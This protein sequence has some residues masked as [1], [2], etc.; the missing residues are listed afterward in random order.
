[1]AS[2]E[3]TAF[4]FLSVS[5]EITGGSVLFAAACGCFPL[6]DVVYC[7]CW[8]F[9]F[10]SSSS[11]HT[12]LQPSRVMVTV[13]TFTSDSGSAWLLP[14]LPPFTS[15]HCVYMHM[16]MCKGARVCLRARCTRAFVQINY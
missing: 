3:I 6:A 10:H 16:Q 13:F 5:K 1:M 11:M 7:C 8:G 14:A 15:Q 4:G 12:S 9:F 2:R